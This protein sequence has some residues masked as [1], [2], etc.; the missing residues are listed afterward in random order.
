MCWT[1][2]WFF[3]KYPENCDHSIAAKCA[4]SATSKTDIHTPQFQKNLAALLTPTVEP[5]CL[6]SPLSLVRSRFPKSLWHLELTY[7]VN[8]PPPLACFKWRN[9]FMTFCRSFLFI[10]FARMSQMLRLFRVWE[11]HK[12][13]KRKKK[14]HDDFWYVRSRR[15]FPRRRG[16]RTASLCFLPQRLSGMPCVYSVFWRKSW[17]RIL[18]KQLWKT[19][20]AASRNIS[21]GLWLWS[22]GL[23]V[24]K[25]KQSIN[26]VCKDKNISKLS[27]ASSWCQSM[28]QPMK[29]WFLKNL[30]VL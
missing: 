15:T 30:K 23:I 19:F 22:F 21:L 13:A 20:A 29:Q 26:M 5:D 11:L 1:C 3:H 12:K 9:L 25:H 4:R 16:W 2:C 8:N 10:W 28:V 24:S 7:H 6:L 27:E 17:H 18:Y 14:P